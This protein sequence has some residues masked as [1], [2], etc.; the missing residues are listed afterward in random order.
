V[1]VRTTDSGLEVVEHRIAT[2]TGLRRDEIAALK[3]PEKI[4]IAAF[5]SIVAGDDNG[6]EWLP[7]AIRRLSI[8]A[9]LALAD[10]RDLLRDW[11][12]REIQRA[13]LSVEYFIRGYGHV[14]DDDEPG[15]PVPFD[16]WPAQVRVLDL[17]ETELRVAVLKARQLGLTWLALHFGVHLIALDPGGR[18]S[19]VLGLSQDGG[20][21]KRLLERVRNINDL[22]PPF[23][24]VDE[25][26]ETAGSKT[27]VK[28]VGRG[29]MVSLPGTPAAPRSW[30]ADLAICDEWAFVRNGQAGPTMRALQPAAR[31]IIAISSGDGGPDEPGWGQ[32]FAQLYV[33]AR[34]GENDWTAVFLP[35]STHPK[36]TP[37]WREAERENYDTEEDFLSEHPETD[38]EALIGAGR[39]RFFKL[40]EIAAA[41]RAW[42]RAGRASRH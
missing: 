39:D 17:F 4:A 32:S 22:L 2:P 38:D 10:D 5:H 11:Q 27:E 23:L 40:G 20:Y 8:E 35:T 6:R 16:L 33:K 21:A 19:V 18:S 30:Q 12:A 3:R 9:R 37:E 28:L 24:H 41:V 42:R 29:R 34:E 31:Q 15:P 13:Q 7:A 26:R 25:E 36:R 1:P 14:R